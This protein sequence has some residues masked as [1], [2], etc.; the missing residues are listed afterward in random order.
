MVVWF[1]QSLKKRNAE[2]TEKQTQRDEITEIQDALIEIAGIVETMAASD[3][4]EEGN[5]G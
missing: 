2:K 4:G 1:K 3:S 5:N